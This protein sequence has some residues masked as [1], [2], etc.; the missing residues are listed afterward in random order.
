MFLLDKFMMTCTV[1]DTDSRWLQAIEG[2]SALRQPSAYPCWMDVARHNYS[3]S[4]NIS[5]LQGHDLEFRGRINSFKAA[6][7]YSRPL[8]WR[9]EGTKVAVGPV[10]KLCHGT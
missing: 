1:E 9:W 6:G 3:H 7:D 10:L 2:S 5:G 8:G 4:A